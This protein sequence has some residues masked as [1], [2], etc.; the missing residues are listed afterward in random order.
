MRCLKN[1]VEQSLRVG[2]G[3]EI[4]PCRFRG[5][6]THFG[7]SFQQGGERKKE[8]NPSALSTLGQ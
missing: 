1:T 5:H 4:F 2:K 8:L 3:G 6:Q 7:M